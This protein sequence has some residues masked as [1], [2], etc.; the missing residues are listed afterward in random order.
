MQEEH[1]ERE[2]PSS[3]TDAEWAV[4]RP[5]LPEAPNGPS[6]ASIPDAILSM[7][8]FASCAAAELG[9]SG[10][11]VWQWISSSAKDLPHM[12]PIVSS[13]EDG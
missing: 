11:H 4:I 5:L 6:P 10:L 1:R 8:S 12:D 13:G 9:G 2:Y 3:L 7:A